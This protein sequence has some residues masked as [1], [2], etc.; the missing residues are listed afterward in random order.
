[1]AATDRTVS[2]RWDPVP[3]PD[4]AE[5]AGIR[6]DLARLYMRHRLTWASR[7]PETSGSL[8]TPTT[9]RRRS[10]SCRGTRSITTTSAGC[11]DIDGGGRRRSG[12]TRARP[13]RLDG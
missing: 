8:P 2:H 11:V 6:A 7:S 1:M 10:G 13:R 9:S 3:D 4:A 5:F 12:C